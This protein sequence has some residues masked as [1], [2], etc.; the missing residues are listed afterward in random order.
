MPILN[1]TT[2]V[3]TARTVGQ[4]QA[5]LAEA[6]ADQ[7]L[8]EYRDKRVVALSFTT[9]TS[10]GP[11]AFRLPA[12]PARVFAVL[13][14]QR[15]APRYATM[16]Q[17]ERVAWRIVKTWIEAQLA[18]IQTEMVTLDQVMLPYMRTD[19]GTTM[20]DRYLEHGQRLLE[21]GRGIDMA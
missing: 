20:Y 8:A 14:R 16:E 18:I 15:V 17:A 7:I 10:T 21:A 13:R 6:G 3:P 2:E 19:N 4:I 5:I 11:Q 1:Y 9:E 12:D